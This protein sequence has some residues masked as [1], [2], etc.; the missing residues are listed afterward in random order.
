VKVVL[1]AK[2][3]EKR[4]TRLIGDPKIEAPWS[5]WSDGRVVT[6]EDFSQGPVDFMLRRKPNDKN[7]LVVKPPG[8]GEI[9]LDRH[10]GT[11]DDFTHVDFIAA[12]LQGAL[13]VDFRYS[14][15]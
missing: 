6:F 5:K 2:T 13:L 4:A 11:I 15:F 9:I 14:K 12:E 8:G 1:G 7:E 10:D 3:I